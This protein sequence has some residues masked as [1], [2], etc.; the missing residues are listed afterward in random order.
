[1]PPKYVIYDLGV[2]ITHLIAK[3]SPGA[4]RDDAPPPPKRKGRSAA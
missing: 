1:M 4:R 3:L 2:V